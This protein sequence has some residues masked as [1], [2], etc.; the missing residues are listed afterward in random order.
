MFDMLIKENDMITVKDFWRAFFV[1][2]AMQ[3]SDDM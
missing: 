1:R 3:I 2:D